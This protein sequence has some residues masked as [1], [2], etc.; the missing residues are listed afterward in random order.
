MALEADVTSI[1][2]LMTII[3]KL[4]VEVMLYV[5][6]PKCLPDMVPHSSQH[7]YTLKITQGPDLPCSLWS[8]SEDLTV[9]YSTICNFTEKDGKMYLK[10]HDYELNL[11]PRN[12]KLYFGNLFNGNKQIGEIDINH[13]RFI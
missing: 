8:V 9:K 1:L 11:D 7:S 6:S 2:T 3:L 13:F 5:H 4:S 12:A 10:P